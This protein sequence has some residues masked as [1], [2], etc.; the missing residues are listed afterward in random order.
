MAPFQKIQN[1]MNVELESIP[2]SKSSKHEDSRSEKETNGD[3]YV[4]KNKSLDLFAGSVSFEKPNRVSYQSNLN[5][6]RKSRVEEM[7]IVRVKGG[8]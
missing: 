6:S 3:S 8:K 1:K 5:H 4:R 7:K 2:D